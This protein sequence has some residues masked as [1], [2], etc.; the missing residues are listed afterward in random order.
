MITAHTVTYAATAPTAAVY[1]EV[2]ATDRKQLEHFRQ[3]QR[4]EI[5]DHA[6]KVADIAPKYDRYT[7]L[8]A[9]TN[10]YTVQSIQPT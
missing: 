4:S 10:R 1:D 3:E 9:I 8:S 2:S 6:S 7:A 5:A